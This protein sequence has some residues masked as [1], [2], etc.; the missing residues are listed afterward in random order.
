MRIG[1]ER[2]ALALSGSA[3]MGLANGDGEGVKLIEEL[4]AGLR[5]V[6]G[7]GHAS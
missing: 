2:A 3:A 7:K 1:G 6:G 5:G 4:D